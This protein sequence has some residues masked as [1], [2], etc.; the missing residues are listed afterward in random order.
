MLERVQQV[1]QEECDRHGMAQLGVG[2]AAKHIADGIALAQDGN[3]RQAFDAFAA[4][5]Q[6]I[7]K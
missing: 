3:Y 1:V 4:A 7:I 5:Y 6:A 2:R